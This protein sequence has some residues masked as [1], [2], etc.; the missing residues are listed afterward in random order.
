MGLKKPNKENDKTFG[1]D[2]V[3]VRRKGRKVKADSKESRT[4]NKQRGYN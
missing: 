1:Y 4:P 3:A 2:A